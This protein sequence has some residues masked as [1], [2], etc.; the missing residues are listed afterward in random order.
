M[1]H[2]PLTIITAMFVH[3]GWIHLLGEIFFLRIQSVT[4]EF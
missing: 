1:V 2:V 4:I 3:G